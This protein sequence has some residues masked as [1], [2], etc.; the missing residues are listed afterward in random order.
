MLKKFLK[1]YTNRM[2]VIFL[3]F[4]L[5]LLAI[6]C[7]AQSIVVYGTYQSSL[8]SQGEVSVESTSIALTTVLSDYTATISN[9]CEEENVQE[10]LNGKRDEDT[11][12]QILK[13]LYFIKNSFSQQADINVIQL[14]TNS[15][16][17]TGDYE[18][19][20]SHRIYSNWGIFRNANETHEV[21]VYAFS[22]DAVL[23][24]QDRICLAKAYRNE[25]NQIL[26]YVMIEITRSALDSLIKEY[27]S[28]Y[29]TS[30]MLINKN[31]SIVYH[32][33]GVDW[34]GVG[35]IEQY[36][37]LSEL[38]EMSEDGLVWG[39]YVGTYNELAETYILREL[40][41][42]AMGVML[43]ILLNTM[44]ICVILIL[45]FSSIFSKIIANSVSYPIRELSEKMGQME[46]GD[47]S[48][49]VNVTRQDEIGYLGDSFNHM[50]ERIETLV[51]N[52][53]EEKHSLWIA[54]TRSLNLQMNPH[55][56]YNTLD[57]I[58]W[59][60]K[61]GRT[62]EISE[63][64]VNL[65]KLLRKVMNTKDDLVSVSYEMDIVSAFVELQKKRHGEKL[66]LITSIQEDVWNQLIPKLTLEPIVENAIVHGF[67]EKA[68][69]CRIEV[70]IEKKEEYLI[71]TVKDN[72]DGMS[73][74][75]LENA[76][77]FRQENTHHIGLSNVQRRAKLYGDE[78]CGLTIRSDE[79]KGTTVVLVL[80]QM[81]EINDKSSIG[82][83]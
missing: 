47:L 78:N 77:E 50:A 7:I 44:I 36:G 62:Q 48:T 73:E 16:I 31:G 22:K 15:W 79:G 29:N 11:K 61:L 54:E 71:L 76:L 58:K 5:A 14:R 82:R 56:L 57:L 60:A 64:A 37:K 80:K 4:S 39:Q 67:E 32:S 9:L 49:R 69:N 59:N 19:F 12:L 83:G 45:F 33:K 46:K 1:S 18:K 17:T 74:E 30:F 43:R 21:A 8:R 51:H 52:V 35:K 53:D 6:L 26:G 27:N 38:K 3:A 20:S 55:F 41:E 13:D 72:G 2:F 68:D 63:I 10:F 75:E 28:V 42:G 24:E 81:G 65:G 40:P 70:F 66:Q 23:K 25:E 34:E